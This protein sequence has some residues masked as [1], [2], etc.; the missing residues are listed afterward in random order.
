MQLS[1]LSLS[2][3]VADMSGYRGLQGHNAALNVIRHIGISQR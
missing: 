2:V 3:C 1:Y